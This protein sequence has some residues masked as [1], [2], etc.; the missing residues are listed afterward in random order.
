[1]GSPGL[2]RRTG[3]GLNVRGS[4]LRHG[5]ALFLLLAT[6]TFLLQIDLWT[7]YSLEGKAT[8]NR[9]AER[10]HTNMDITSVTQ[11]ATGCGTFSATVGNAGR[12]SVS[13][14][15][16]MDVLIDYN[17]GADAKVV[18]YLTNEADWSVTALSPD[19]YD[20]NIWKPLESATIVF[21]AVPP[22]KAVKGGEKLYQQGVDGLRLCQ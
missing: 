13:D 4:K 12:T 14:F 9:R 8:A 20:K 19:T 7:T 5:P 1:M 22:P 10:L 15:T 2:V 18:S 3:A 16:Q 6:A 17:D 21:A 11:S